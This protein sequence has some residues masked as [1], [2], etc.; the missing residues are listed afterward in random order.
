MKTKTPPTFL[1]TSYTEKLMFP[2]KPSREQRRALVA[3]GFRWSGLYWW[4]NQNQTLP[5]KAADLE[6][7]LAPVAANDNTPLSEAATG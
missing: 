1:R 5:I 2:G 7:L 6:A 3:A 4:R